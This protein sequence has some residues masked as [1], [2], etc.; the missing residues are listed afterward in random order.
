MTLNLTQYEA[1]YN[2]KFKLALST[3]EKCLESMGQ[4]PPDMDKGYIT[5]LKVSDINWHKGFYQEVC[6]IVGSIL[7]SSGY[8]H[9]FKIR[10]QQNGMLR[11]IHDISIMTDAEKEDNLKDPDELELSDDESSDDE[12]E[13]V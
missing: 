4:R 7:F 6:T 1:V 8:W 3:S 5:R 11:I 9:S 2:Q 10:K 13:I 12:T